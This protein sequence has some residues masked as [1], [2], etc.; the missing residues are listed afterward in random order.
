MYLRGILPTTDAVRVVTGA[1]DAVDAGEL[2][3]YEIPLTDDGEPVTAP[4]V[5]GWVRTLATGGPVAPSAFVMGMALVRVDPAAVAI[6]DPP[7]GDRALRMLRMLAWPSVE[8]PPRPALC[9]F[10]FTGRDRL[11]LYVAVDEAGG[12]VAAD[13]R[14]RAP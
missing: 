4:M 12:L 7:A 10:L 1:A 6:A 11:R 2:T 9:G 8:S 3:A 14:L 5:L 13:V